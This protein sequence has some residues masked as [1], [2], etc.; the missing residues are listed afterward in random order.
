MTLNDTADTKVRI[1]I[2]ASTYS[3]LVSNSNGEP[4][5]VAGRTMSAGTHSINLWCRDY[6]RINRAFYSP[7]YTPGALPIIG[8]LDLSKMLNVGSN[9]L[10]EDLTLSLPPTCENVIFPTTTKNVDVYFKYTLPATGYPNYSG[11]P[12]FSSLDVSMMPNLQSLT[13]DGTSVTT[14]QGA[15]VRQLTFTSSG[16]PYFDLRMGGAVSYNNDIDLSMFTNLRNLRLSELGTNGSPSINQIIW[17]TVTSSAVP[18]IFYMSNCNYSGYLPLNQIYSTFSNSMNMGFALNSGLTGVGFPTSSNSFSNLWAYSCN[19]TGELDISMLSGLGGTVRFYSN[20]NLTSIK[21]PT[22]S[23]VFSSYEVNNCG[24]S[25]SLDVSGL[26]GLGG[27]FIAYS[28]PN[29]KSIINPT[30]S[31]I[32]SQYYAYSCGLTGSL[33][34]SGLSKLG[35]LIQL[36]SNPNLTS[37]INPSSTQSISLYRVDSCDLTSLDMSTLTN[38]SGTINYNSNPNLTQVTHATNSSP[39]TVYSGHTTGISSLDI[40][41]LNI[42]GQFFAHANPNLTSVSLPSTSGPFSIFYI[43]SSNLIGTLDVSGVSFSNGVNFRVYSNG[44]LTNII[45]GTNSSTFTSYHA[46]SCNLDYIDFNFFQNMTDINSCNIRLENNGMTTSDVNHILFDLDN[47]ST[48]GF[49]SRIINL[50]GTNAAPNDVTGWSG[51]TAKASLV[52]KNFTVTTN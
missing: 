45:H 5:A 11:G 35:G 29:L 8:T 47:I 52:S 10:T 1:R 18:S 14:N 34:L 41:N 4:I 20:P 22:S 43:Y 24:L 26:T 19:I 6:S 33:N 13:F 50:S 42:N 9:T 3:Y 40:S 46:Y 16:A 39:I 38:M 27:Q 37:I 7:F 2:E 31:T 25:G 49:T 32:F 44:N 15:N 28:N 12:S 30:S 36:N 48:S 51:S 17:P 23:V 21:N